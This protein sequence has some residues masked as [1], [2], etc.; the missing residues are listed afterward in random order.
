MMTYNFDQL[1]DRRNSYSMKWDIKD[2]EL[3][4]W[5][6]DMDFQT[7][8]AVTDAIQKRA[9][10]GIFGY[11]I[12]PDD[13]REAYCGWWKRRHNL[14]IAP[15]SLVFVLVWFGPFQ[16]RPQND[17]CGRECAGTDSGI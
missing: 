7:V 4:M 13:W 1:N 17:N 6:A 3:P 11:T 16:H 8:P 12:I 9:K 2:N 14:T 5:V 10:Q 15:E